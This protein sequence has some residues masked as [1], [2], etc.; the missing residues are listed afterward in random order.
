MKQLFVGFTIVAIVAGL[1]SCVKP[2]PEVADDN[3][4]DVKFTIEYVDSF[5]GHNLLDTTNANIPIIDSASVKVYENTS[6][7]PI[8]QNNLTAGLYK[9]GSN[10]GPVMYAA[11]F[12]NSEGEFDFNRYFNKHQNH[13]YLIQRPSKD[14]L[15]METDSIRVQ[16]RYG[17]TDCNYVW[18]YIRFWVNGEKRD[19]LEFNQEAVIKI[20]L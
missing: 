15:T 20:R 1:S 7:Q 6:G 16:F 4:K 13:M 19:D 18:Q 10:I 5:D 8:A 9:K 11:K 12:L 14:G 3:V 2:C 17:G